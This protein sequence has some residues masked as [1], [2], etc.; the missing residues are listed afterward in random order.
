MTFEEA[1][2]I[3]SRARDCFLKGKC[4]GEAPTLRELTDA[5][6]AFGIEEAKCKCENCER[7]NICKEHYDRVAEVVKCN[8]YVEKQ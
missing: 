2:D 1:S 4:E 8:F 3:R 6:L 5:T 7:F